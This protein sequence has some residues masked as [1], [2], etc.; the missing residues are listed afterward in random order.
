MSF[1]E[2][3]ER[4]NLW[5]AEQFC[6]FEVAG[7]LQ[8]WMPADFA[9]ALTAY[10]DLFHLEAGRILLSP[11]L[12]T[13]EARSR[14][15]EDRLDDIIARGLGPR[16]RRELYPVVR[17]WGEEPAFLLDRGAVPY[18][19]TRSFGVHLNGYLRK[20]GEIHLW[21]G[22]RNRNKPV[23]PG[24]LDHIVA[25]GQPHGLSPFDNLIK[26]S[27]EEASLP[28]EVAS[29][30]RAVGSISYRC[31]WEGEQVRDDVLFI[32]D[33]ELPESVEPRPQDD[34]VEGFE[35]MP[36][37]EA[38]ER[39]RDSDD[40]KFNVNLVLIDFFLRHG[41]LDRNDPGVAALAERL[42]QPLTD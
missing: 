35:L 42:Y 39:V 6:R 38:L 17:R 4:C 18:F 3:I 2:H 33:L 30:A 12:E 23:A 32:Y 41:A 28:E 16:R 11:A 25:G 10:P 27:W 9:Q 31:L 37:G 14:A 1:M 7:R 13:P 29:Q 36:I 26:E 5:P 20:G 24:K 19:G 15:I 34:E 22:R 21:V 40:F 8:G